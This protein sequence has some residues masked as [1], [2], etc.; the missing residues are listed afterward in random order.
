MSGIPFVLELTLSCGVVWSCLFLSCACLLL[1]FSSAS[2]SYV[3]HFLLNL[4]LKRSLDSITFDIRKL[5][6]SGFLHFCLMN[7][8][9]DHVVWSFAC[10]FTCCWRQPNNIFTSTISEWALK[11]HVFLFRIYSSNYFSNYLFIEIKA[12]CMFSP[13]PEVWKGGIYCSLRLQKYFDS[14]IC[15]NILTQCINVNLCITNYDCW[16]QY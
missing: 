8:K 15:P 11:I 5:F 2:T 13:N 12:I 4:I 6:P 16:K 14:R 3:L 1:S 10:L 7:T 9:T